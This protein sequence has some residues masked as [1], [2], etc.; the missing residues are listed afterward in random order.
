MIYLLVSLA[1]RPHSGWELITT[2]IDCYSI[3][4]ACYFV[5]TAPLLHLLLHGFYSLL[6]VYAVIT[7][8]YY[9]VMRFYYLLLRSNGSIT[10]CYYHS[11][12][13]VT[14][15]YSGPQK[16]VL[17]SLLTDP[18]TC[19]CKIQKSHLNFKPLFLYGFWGY[20]DVDWYLPLTLWIAIKLIVHY[21]CSLQNFPHLW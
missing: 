9:L 13:I 11:N 12:G 17:D 4:T 14:A 1:L 8:Y 21:C 3:I 2:I 6:Q 16:V 10:T 20:S 19:R 5:I 18:R 15:H 7:T